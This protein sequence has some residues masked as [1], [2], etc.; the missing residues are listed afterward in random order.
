MASHGPWWP[1][2][3][4]H[5]SSHSFGPVPLLLSPLMAL[6]RPNTGAFPVGLTRHVVFPL[7]HQEKTKVSQPLDYENVISQRKAQIYSDPF[8]DLLMFPMEDASVSCSP[9]LWGVRRVLPTQFLSGRPYQAAIFSPC[10][11]HQRNGPGETW[12]FWDHVW[13]PIWPWRYQL[14][15]IPQINPRRLLGQR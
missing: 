4:A 5:I 7:S 15:R 13:F 12:L 10:L 3:A 9:L 14:R 11:L 1:L 8:R 6:V 2:G